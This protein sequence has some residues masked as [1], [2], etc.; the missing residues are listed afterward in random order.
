[1]NTE[2]RFLPIADVERIFNKLANTYGNEWTAKWRGA[3]Y[4]RLQMEWAE[5]LGVL[6]EWQ[7]DFALANLPERAPNLIAFKKLALEATGKTRLDD[8]NEW[9]WEP[10]PRD[11]SA[12]IGQPTM[13]LVQVPAGTAKMPLHRAPPETPPLT[14]AQRARSMAYMAQTWAT[15]GYH[16]N[17]DKARAQ[18]AEFVELAR[19]A[20]EQTPTATALQDEAARDF[21]AARA[22][23]LADEKRGL[24][25]P[26]RPQFDLDALLARRGTKKEEKRDWA[27]IIAAKVER[28]GQV[29]DYAVKKAR[30]A[31]DGFEGERWLQNAPRRAEV[32]EVMPAQ[33]PSAENAPSARFDAFAGAEDLSW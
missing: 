8:G 24:V 27:R 31:L 22:R 21:A 2:T 23:Q 26:A 16:E 1:M 5:Q 13:R 7:V 28:G 14:M 15:L 18:C 19:D 10:I 9:A 29:S 17:A 4:G 30:A 12:P 20:G 25:E 3:D 11:G 33:M 6:Q 32:P